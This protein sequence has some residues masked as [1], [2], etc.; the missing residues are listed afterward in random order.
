MDNMETN[1]NIFLKK[2]LAYRSRALKFDLLGPEFLII[3]FL[4]IVLLTIISGG[5]AGLAFGTLFSLNVPILLLIISV[6][7]GVISIIFG[8]K[9]IV[10]ARQGGVSNFSYFLI[11]N[12]GFLEIFLAVIILMTVTPWKSTCL[13]N[14]Y[15][16]TAGC[17][18]I[19]LLPNSLQQDYSNNS[20]VAFTENGAEQ[21][22]KNMLGDN[23]NITN[24]AENSAGWIF[25]YSS[26]TDPSVVD[27]WSSK[28]GGGGSGPVYV[29][30][31]NQRALF[32]NSF[33]IN[34]GEIP[35]SI[36]I[37]LASGASDIKENITILVP[38]H[39][40]TLTAGTTQEITWT[41]GP[42][43]CS[44]SEN[45]T[46]RLY[47]ISLMGEET[48][49]YQSII[50]GVGAYS[51]NWNIPSSLVGNDYVIQVCQENS[52]ICGSSKVGYRIFSGSN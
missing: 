6:P 33:S 27:S 26:K 42:L 37:Y 2:A 7:C 16:G 19:A 23:Y 45:C 52:D 40:D 48:Q 8:Y 44:S 50:K 1:Q 39:N 32:L 3:L 43:I 10:I 41:Q 36:T 15:P 5:F 12:L 24:V 20:S 31:N 4:G 25:D 9:A 13:F 30:K 35:D 34:E 21:V 11:A 38:S 49:K 14:H 28:Y 17:L 29:D 18:H 47:D 51:Y 46:P 22:A